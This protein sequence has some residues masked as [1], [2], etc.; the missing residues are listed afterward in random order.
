M[1]KNIDTSDISLIYPQSVLYA[2]GFN[3]RAAAGLSQSNCRALELDVLIDLK[4]SDLGD[5]FTSDPETI[6]YRQKTFADLSDNPQLCDVLRRM[7]P[8]LSD[9]IELRRMGGDLAAENEGTLYSITEV[10]LYLSLLEMLSA[11]L[12]PLEDKLTSEALKTFCQRI[13]TALSPPTI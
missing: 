12:L 3:N 8:L 5:F 9:I 13:K 1:E 6:R 10:E 4:N 2:D 7:V 11:E